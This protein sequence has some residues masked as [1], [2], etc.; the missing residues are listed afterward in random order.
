VAG[1]VAGVRARVESRLALRPLPV[2]ADLA[3]RRGRFGLGRVRA[4][5]FESQELRKGV[6]AEVALRPV[7][8]GLALVLAPRRD[9]DAPLFAADLMVLPTRLAA[10]ADV[11]GD[12][13]RTRGLLA[14]LAANFARLGGGAGPEWTA[15][16]GSNEGLHARPSLRLVDELFASVTGALGHYIDV[17]AAA[18]RGVD[19]TRE[20][21]DFFAAFYA[22]G[23][24]A[25]A[26][27]RVFGAAWAERFT[28]LL[29]E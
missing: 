10:N 2:D 19:T 25:G 8:E 27:G 24:R 4:W 7:V 21:G 5:A 29:F 12:P 26:L 15:R 6:I 1:M 11:Y 13:H 22:H 23:P 18:P 17:L 20:Q 14:P 3:D 9:V 16:I 28:R